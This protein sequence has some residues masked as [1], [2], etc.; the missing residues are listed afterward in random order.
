MDTPP[1]I[2]RRYA[3]PPRETPLERR[4]RLTNRRAAKYRYLRSYATGPNVLNPVVESQR[5]ENRR[6]QRE[7]RAVLDAE[8][9]AR[10]RAQ[11]RVR[12]QMR[13]KKLSEEAKASIRAAQ[14]ERQRR[15]RETLDD[16]AR[17]ALRQRERLRITKKRRERKKEQ[18]EKRMM[19]LL[20]VSV[21]LVGPERE[22]LPHLRL[23]PELPTLR[24]HQEQQRHRAMQNR[25]VF[26]GS[27]P[28]TFP[29]PVTPVER[30]RMFQHERMVSLPHL[31]QVARPSTT[32]SLLHS[33]QLSSF[34][35]MAGTT[36]EGAASIASPGL[37]TVA[38]AVAA[39]ATNPTSFIPGVSLPLP[40]KMPT[41]VS[42]QQRTPIVLPPAH[43]SL[44]PLP[45]FLNSREAFH[46]TPAAAAVPATS[47]RTA[48][49]TS[50]VNRALFPSILDLSLVHADALDADSLFQR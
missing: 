49:P 24:Q 11:N 19:E 17:A 2:R 31:Q 20:P 48:R 43:R 47:T 38:T 42:Q 40:T 26:N 23:A 1:S 46:P 9:R 45:N 4:R 21:P 37:P 41:T 32:L 33:T 10:L 3:S 6:R 14:R 12:Q 27:A 25:L 22:K 15:R 28:M 29:L 39:A 34:F 5:Q 8:T 16:T 30:V 18:E 7:R 13:R 36:S 44:P 35:P 50:N